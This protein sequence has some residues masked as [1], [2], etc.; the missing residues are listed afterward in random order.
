VKNRKMKIILSENIFNHIISGKIGI[1]RSR[2]LRYGKYRIVRRY[3]K[4]S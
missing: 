3:T 1:V 4:V 2:K